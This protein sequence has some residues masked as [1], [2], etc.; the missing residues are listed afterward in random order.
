[1]LD[2]AAHQARRRWSASCCSASC[3][4]SALSGRVRTV[5]LSV[6]VLLGLE[7][8]AANVARPAAALG[9]P[10]LSVDGWRVVGARAARWHVDPPG[11]ARARSRPHAGGRNTPGPH[12]L[13]GAVAYGL[14]F[15]SLVG[16][17]YG[18]RG[19]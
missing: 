9:R 5:A 4:A 10:A 18:V 2:H 7:G 17:V 11:A 14:G 16:H 13:L 19:R 3:S 15:V 12:R 1:M 6:V 8:I